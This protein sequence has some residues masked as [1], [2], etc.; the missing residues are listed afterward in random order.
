[1]VFPGLFSS[2]LLALS[3]FAIG[4]WGTALGGEDLDPA[5]S[6]SQADKPSSARRYRRCAGA[7]LLM[8]HV[9]DDYPRLPQ[10]RPSLRTVPSTD[11]QVAAPA[12]AA[13]LR[14]A[15]AAPED[16]LLETLRKLWRRRWLIAS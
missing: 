4:F 8:A 3:Y 11:R 5:F 12:P 13:V 1:M 7:V 15:A 14:P 10:R 9:P 2:F 6:Q 16:G